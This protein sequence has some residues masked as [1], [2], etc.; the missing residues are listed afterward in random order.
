[1]WF[2]RFS[3]LIPSLIVEVYLQWK[4]QIS[5][6]FV[7]GETWKIV[8]VSNTYLA[9]CNLKAETCFAYKLCF[10]TNGITVEYLSQECVT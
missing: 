6:F 5:P 4:L 10:S 3:F 2:S 8:S 9:H 7:S 1:M